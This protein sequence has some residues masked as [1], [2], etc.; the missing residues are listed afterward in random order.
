MVA[1]VPAFAG[2]TLEQG[3]GAGAKAETA[4]EEECTLA[5]VPARCW[6]SGRA[7]VLRAFRDDGFLLQLPT[8][9]RRLPHRNSPMI[10]GHPV[11]E[12]LWLA[13]AIGVGGVASGLFAGLFGVG[14]GAVIVPVLFEVFRVF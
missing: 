10:L 11:S 6:R 3:A 12:I 13:M 8:S 2:M 9:S 1:W 5:W 7:R 14:G 4:V